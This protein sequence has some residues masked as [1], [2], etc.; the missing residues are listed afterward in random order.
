MHSE[1]K[2]LPAFIP[3]IRCII[4]KHHL[5][6]A[7]M[8]SIWET[9]WGNSTIAI[10]SL[11]KLRHR[12]TVIQL[13]LVKKMVLK[14][15]VLPG[16]LL[17]LEKW[18]NFLL[19]LWGG[20]SQSIREK[21]Q[22]VFKLWPSLTLSL[23]LVLLTTSFAS[24]TKRAKEKMLRKVWRLTTGCFACLSPVAFSGVMNWVPASQLSSSWHND[25]RKELANRGC[26]FL[27]ATL[28]IPQGLHF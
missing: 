26:N 4:I 5:D 3:T 9:Q 28:A 23:F 13:T 15:R 11:Q 18:L 19:N 17:M 22:S 25:R 27:S 10:L 24:P 20:R 8:L 14:W 1:I 21:A 12:W 7:K 2:I 6:A 16:L